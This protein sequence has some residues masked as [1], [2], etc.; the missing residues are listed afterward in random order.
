LVDFPK[1]RRLPAALAL[2]VLLTAIAAASLAARAGADPGRRVVTRTELLVDAT[3]DRTLV[4][5]IRVP[6]SGGPYPLVVL[7]HGLNG[8]PRK[9][10]RLL[11]TWA[12]AGYVV[13]APAFP[14]TN[15]ETGTAFVAD[16]DDQP[17]DVS[18]VIDEVLRLSRDRGDAL[19]GRVD[20]SRIGVA[21]L[22]LGGGTV[23]G[24]TYNDCCRD[25]RVDAVISMA[26]FRL[27]FDGAYALEGVPLLLMHGDADLAAPY[28][29]AETVYAEAAAPKYLVTVV[30]G[31]HAPP[32]E[33][34]VDPADAVVETVTTD[35]WNAYLKGRPAALRRLPDDAM[36][37]G[38]TTIEYDAG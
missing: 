18:F 33:D 2:T 10:S 28:S 17:A 6:S 14:F 15:D 38:V 21:G 5:T 11:E 29:G 26:G 4:T 20:R 30:G 31:T 36:V 32:F 24:L 22:S 7:A 25:D 13:A 27:P 16:Y 1:R 35:F 19:Y 8:H 9:F 34:A 37:A 23:L 12:R 3:R